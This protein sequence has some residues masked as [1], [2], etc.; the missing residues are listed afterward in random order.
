[1]NNKSYDFRIGS[2]NVRGINKHSKRISIFNWIRRQQFDLMFL[3]ETFSS[4][5]E[6]S[7]WQSEWEGKTVWA[8][9]SKHSRGVGI[10]VKKGFDFEHKDI[11]VDPDGRYIIINSMIQGENMWLVNIY[12][13]N[14]KRDKAVFFEHLH[15]K[16]DLIGIDKS[17][18]L[19][20]GGDWNTILSPILDKSGGKE[21][22]D[23]TVT[24]EMKTILIDFDLIDIWRLKHPTTKRFTYRQKKPLIQTRLD[25]FLVSN[26]LID[27]IEK[28]QILASYCSD[29]SCVSLNMLSLPIQNRG[30]VNYFL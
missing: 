3:Q 30:K 28:P 12:A 14:S 25:Y 16:F 5:D 13:P 29:H 8:H 17:D 10:L 22:E 11:I 15:N 21:L 18:P 4:K 24:N 6:E 26:I 2:L 1:M 23:E 7:L 27:V 20:I 19:L 9:G